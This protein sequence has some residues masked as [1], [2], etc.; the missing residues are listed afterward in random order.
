MINQFICTTIFFAINMEGSEEGSN[1]DMA[2]S[3]LEAFCYEQKFFIDR[4]DDC[5]N[6]LANYT[7]LK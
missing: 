3:A 5:Y 2:C 7:N 6:I 4:R 1:H